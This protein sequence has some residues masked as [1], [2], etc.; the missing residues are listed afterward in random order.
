MPKNSNRGFPHPGHSDVEASSRIWRLIKRLKS[1]PNSESPAATNPKNPSEIGYS[2]EWLE[3]CIKQVEDAYTLE[4]AIEWHREVL[5]E[6][7]EHI[8]VVQN[9][10]WPD[11]L[12]RQ[13]LFDLM[14]IRLEYRICLTNLRN[15]QASDEVIRWRPDAASPSAPD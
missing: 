14:H 15:V 12:K 5:E 2:A 4:D 9:K 11:N 10:Q 1:F 6:I 8:A 3:H 13:T 7:E